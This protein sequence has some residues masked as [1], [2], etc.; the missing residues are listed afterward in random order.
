MVN[1][2]FELLLSSSRGFRKL[3]FDRE[4]N[5]VLLASRECLNALSPGIQI[6]L[7]DGKPITKVFCVCRERAAMVWPLRCLVSDPLITRSENLGGR[8]EKFFIFSSILKI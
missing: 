1:N 2:G 3:A 4:S 5:G 8:E 6:A 7:S